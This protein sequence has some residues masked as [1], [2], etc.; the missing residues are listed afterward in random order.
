MRD[1][2]DG[3][4]AEWLPLLE[5]RPSEALTRVI[6]DLAVCPDGDRAALV[7]RFTALLCGPRA[8]PDQVRLVMR[9]LARLTGSAPQPAIATSPRLEELA[10]V[11]GALSGRLT[12][13]EQGGGS[14][15]ETRCRA[16]ET[17]AAAARERAESLRAMLLRAGCTPEEV[18]L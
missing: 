3:Y 11:E 5:K 18:T 16:L 2:F 14:E 13:L 15:A 6:S 7:H 17:A 8:N 12:E 10:R 1:A 9:H 4:A